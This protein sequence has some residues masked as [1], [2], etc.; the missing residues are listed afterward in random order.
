[1]ISA[2]FVSSGFVKLRNVSNDTFQNVL[3]I[4]PRVKERRA[5]VCRNPESCC[6]K[7]CKTVGV[8]FSSAD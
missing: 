6:R 5:S 4:S 7:S 2:V 1:M 8:Q 3:C